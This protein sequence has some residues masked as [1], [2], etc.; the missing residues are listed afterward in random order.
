[1]LAVPILVPT[2]ANGCL[3]DDCGVRI[4]DP[5]VLDQRLEE[6]ARS[7]AIPPVPIEAFVSASAHQ[8]LPS[9]VQAARERFP[10]GHLRPIHRARAATDPAVREISRRARR[11]GSCRTPPGAG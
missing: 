4:A 2:L 7:S 10:R 8:P 1:M 9:P 6:P 3:C 11:R 5:D